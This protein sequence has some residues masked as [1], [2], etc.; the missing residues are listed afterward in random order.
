MSLTT[1]EQRAA[2]RLRRCMAGE[3][4]RAVFDDRIGSGVGQSGVLIDRALLSEALLREHPND[5][6][7]WPTPEW[8]T[9]IGATPVP[10]EPFECDL[11]PIRLSWWSGGERGDWEA[12][13]GNAAFPGMNTRGHVRR[14]CAALGVHL[15]TA[16]SK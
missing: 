4:V 16:V 9:E 7:E 12:T 1:E 6:G 15:P 13:I 3:D 14:L 11:G 2:D 10:G 8:L 5:D